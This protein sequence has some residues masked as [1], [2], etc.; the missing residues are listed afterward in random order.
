MVECE[1]M[2]AAEKA[3]YK[4]SKSTNRKREALVDVQRREVGE[5]K[6]MR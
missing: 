6:E 2:R 4:K 3:L 1:E 5:C